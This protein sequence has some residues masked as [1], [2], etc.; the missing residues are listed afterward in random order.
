MGGL[1]G[2]GGSRVPLVEGTNMSGTEGRMGIDIDL[3][4]VSGCEGKV[5]FKV[6]IHGV[7]V[8][9]WEAYVRGW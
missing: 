2:P 3:T 1:G 8:G 6:T 7:R 5:S 9:T 4:R